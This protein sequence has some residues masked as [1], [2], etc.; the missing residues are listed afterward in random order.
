LI[1]SKKK[2]DSI[3]KYDSTISDGS[4]NKAYNTENKNNNFY[5]KKP[6]RSVLK[7]LFTNKPQTSHFYKPSNVKDW[8]DGEEKTKKSKANKEKAEQLPSSS[9]KTDRRKSLRRALA[10]FDCLPTLIHQFEKMRNKRNA[11]KFQ[12]FQDEAPL[13]SY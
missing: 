3:S 6:K 5:L 9:N 13:K 7:K 8:N 2:T 12:K 1:D 10:A 11:F 4:N